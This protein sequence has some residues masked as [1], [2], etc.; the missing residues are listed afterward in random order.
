SVDRRSRALELS[1]FSTSSQPARASSSSAARN[2]AGSLN[3]PVALRMILYSIAPEGSVFI[4]VISSSSCSRLR[5]A[6]AAAAAAAD[7]VASTLFDAERLAQQPG[8]LGG[9]RTPKDQNAGPVCCSVLFG[10]D[11]LQVR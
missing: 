10:L 2:L 11:R 8:R 5:R 3:A 9:H 6:A 4:R 1:S 7:I